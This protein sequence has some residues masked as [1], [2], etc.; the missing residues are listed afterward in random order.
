MNEESIKLEGVVN[1]AKAESLF[2]EME[3]IV[4]QCLPTKIHASEVSRVDTAALQ[5]LASFISHMN[6]AGA[7]VEW[8]GV[9]DELLA[10]AKLLGMEQALNLPV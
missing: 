9:S 3:N 10:A 4:R 1:I 5:L 7:K 6:T 8:S 2:H